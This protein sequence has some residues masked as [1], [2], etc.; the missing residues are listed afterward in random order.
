M[1]WTEQRIETLRKL[2]GQGQTA[3]QIAA[4]LGGITR[5]AVIGKAHRLGLTGRPSPIKREAG[6][7]STAQP[8]RKA[9]TARQD[10]PERT[11]RP[12]L[13][14]PMAPSPLGNTA[15]A[16]GISNAAAGASQPAAPSARPTPEM[17]NKADLPVARHPQPSRAHGGS[18]SCSWPVGD[19]KQP[20]FHFCGEPAEPGRPYCGEHC[21]VA[22][23]RKSEAA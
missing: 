14:S 1:E 10:R 21:H 13:T 5:N 15:S 7:G 23:H 9:A 22:Y 8:R 18:K 11:A 6:S 16:A 12:A 17:R 20:G 19:P 2:W 4:I 3:S